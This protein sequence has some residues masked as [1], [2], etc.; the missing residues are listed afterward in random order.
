MANNMDDIT[1][2]KARYVELVRKE[3]FLK[4]QGIYL[5]EENP[6]EDL[7]LLSYQVILESQIYCNRRADYISLVEE[8]LR[9]NVGEDGAR[10][11]MS[12][13]YIIF[14]QDRK[15]LE[16]LEQGIQRFATLRIDPK[17]REFSELINHIAG[18]CES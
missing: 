10:L 11:F 1:F 16:I 7:E 13:F 5:D 17:S 4:N 6:K 2:D 14:K 8:Y 15:A 18:L 12:E 3:E 9:E